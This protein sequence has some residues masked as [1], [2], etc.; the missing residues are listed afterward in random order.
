MKTKN[1]T[2]VAVKIGNSKVRFN[3]YAVAVNVQGWEWFLIKES[4]EQ[5]K[6]D[7]ANGIA[8]CFVQSPLCPEG[9][10]GSEY[11]ANILEHS[12]SI[13][14]PWESMPPVGYQWEDQL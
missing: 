2:R 13:G 7:I 6:E 4:D 8:F 11:E 12:Q 14:S 9:E 10:Y 1:K 5:L 3:C